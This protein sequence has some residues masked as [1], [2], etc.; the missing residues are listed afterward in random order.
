[1][2]LWRLN[3]CI[4]QLQN[5]P[6]LV[7]TPFSPRVLR[8][9]VTPSISSRLLLF[10]ALLL[11][12]LLLIGNVLPSLG[13]TPPPLP[14]Y[15]VVSWNGLRNSAV[16]LSDFLVRHGVKVACLQETK[17]SA[18]VLTPKFPDYTVVRR[19]RPTGS[20]GGLVTLIHH[21]LNYVEIT[22]PINNNFVE[23]IIIKTSISWL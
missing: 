2:G 7:W 19:D 3:A 5:C 23:T 4:R 20:G 9:A 1:M 21:L 22:S 17:L 6:Y 8:P 10:Y 13:P 12:T 18:N 11:P 15:N 14:S 16:E